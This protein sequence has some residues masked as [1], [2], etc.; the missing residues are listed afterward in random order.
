MATAARNNANPDLQLRAIGYLGVMGSAA[1]RE[2][3]A[4]VYRTASSASVKHAILQGYFLSG[5]VEKLGEL[6]KT[7]ADPELRRTAVRNLG[8]MN[9]PGVAETL[10]AIYGA[11]TST[12]VRQAVVNGLFLQ[13]NAK[14][15]VDLARGERDPRM[16]QDIVAKLS[17]MKAPEA[18]DYL[19]ELLK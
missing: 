14:A 4:E 8:M 6:A 19:L 15:L 17:L 3:L 2:L 10:M 11:D 18:T 16:K 12:D 5:N 13:H 1:D 9:R 7:E